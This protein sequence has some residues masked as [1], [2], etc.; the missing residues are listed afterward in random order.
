MTHPDDPKPFVPAPPKVV[1]ERF[2]VGRLSRHVLVCGGP[3]CCDEAAGRHTFGVIKRGCASLNHTSEPGGPQVYW[4]KCECLRL[5]HG[6]PI[7]VV[8]PEG[9]WY[10]NV[11]PQG[12]QRIVDEHL[13]HGRVVEELAFARD[14]LGYGSGGET[15]SPQTDSPVKG[16]CCDQD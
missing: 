16:S 7:V 10:E 8:Y 15:N 6:G 12:A 3:K 13:A 11:T 4:T 14:G 2:G 1:A 5:C 9:V